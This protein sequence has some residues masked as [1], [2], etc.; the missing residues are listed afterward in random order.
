MRWWLIVLVPMFLGFD[1]RSG[2]D[3]QTELGVLSCTLAQVID[4]TG[5]D[6]KTAA[7][8][9]REMICFFLPG[10][11]GPREAYAGTV[12]SI[13]VVGKLPDQLTL[14]WVVKGPLG[15]Q[16]PAGLLQQSYAVDDATPAGQVPPLVGDRNNKIVLHA[17]ADKREGN[18]SQEKQPRPDFLL[19]SVEL[20]LKVSTS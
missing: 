6:Q 13:S 15:T 7:S 16:L 4:S 19:T 3:V 2:S 10:T 12:R 14:L 9:A 18:A 1:A 5:S 17:M 20:I 11:H 8:E